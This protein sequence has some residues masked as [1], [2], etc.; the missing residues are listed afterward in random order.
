MPKSNLALIGFACDEG[1]RRNN[2]RPGAAGGP[3]YFRQFFDEPI[4]DAGDIICENDDLE[5]AQEALAEA[6]Y[7]QFGEGRIPLV[8]GGGH[9][10]A[11]GEYMG[12]QKAYPDS[13]C[14][15]INFDAHFDLRPLDPKV[16]ST[17]GTSFTQ[18]AEYSEERGIPFHYSCLGVQKSGNSNLLFERA[19][20]CAVN[21]ILAE[22]LSLEKVERLLLPEE[23]LF[24]S[25]CLDVFKTPGVSAVQEKGLSFEQVVPYLKLIIEKQ[26][27]PSFYCIAELAP[28][29]DVEGVTGTLAAEVGVALT[30]A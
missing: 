4:Y 6:V 10:L 22:E 17:S 14:H 1:I 11:W 26:A 5:R 19:E 16:G 28:N 7:Q 20:E 23:P 27:A 13:P 12:F 29:H 24:L 8:V 18:I 25:I 15:I 3:A 9:E 30:T 21:T 2:G